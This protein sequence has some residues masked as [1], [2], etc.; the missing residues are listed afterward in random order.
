MGHRREREKEGGGRGKGGGEVGGGGWIRE[1][2]TLKNY[3]SLKMGKGRRARKEE[4]GGT[5]GKTGEKRGKREGGRRGGG[6][7]GRTEEE[8]SETVEWRARG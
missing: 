7:V 1:R 6:E 3:N 5:E 2:K 8:E 4:E